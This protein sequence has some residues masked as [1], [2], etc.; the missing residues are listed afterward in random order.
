MTKYFI[1][2]FDCSSRTHCISHQSTKYIH[3]PLI[4]MF[5]VFYGIFQLNFATLFP[6]TVSSKRFSCRRCLTS[7]FGLNGKVSRLAFSTLKLRERKK[8]EMSRR[9]LWGH[10]RT[11]M[12]GCCCCSCGDV[13]PFND[14]MA[15]DDDPMPSLSS[16]TL[17]IWI[18]DHLINHRLY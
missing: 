18:W 1:H 10:H 9:C 7:T 12:P 17:I 6:F 13:I 8:G 4:Y 2:V 15:N 11:H 5:H 14:N 3:F 16:S